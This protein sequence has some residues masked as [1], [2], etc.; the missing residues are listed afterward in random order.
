MLRQ[1]VDEVLAGHGSLVLVSG[2]AGVGKNTLSRW[3]ALS[4]RPSSA[5]S[6]SSRNRVGQPT[7]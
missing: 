7:W 1:A 2:E 4:G 3:S 5:C 6:G